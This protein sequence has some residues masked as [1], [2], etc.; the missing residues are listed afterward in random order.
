MPFKCRDCRREFPTTQ[1]LSSHRRS[2]HSETVPD[3]FLPPDAQPL[4]I[5]QSVSETVLLLDESVLDLDAI[6]TAIEDISDAKRLFDQG[7]KVLH[8]NSSSSSIQSSCGIVYIRE[9]NNL[10]SFAR[11]REKYA[12]YPTMSDFKLAKLKRSAGLS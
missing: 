9:L 7:P 2:K 6:N 1:G 8:F 3:F 10:P 11:K 5:P 4:P 12:P